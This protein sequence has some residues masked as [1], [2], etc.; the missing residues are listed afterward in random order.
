M[1]PVGVPDPEGERGWRDVGRWGATT[2]AI[3][4]SFLQFVFR[5]PLR[6][7]QELWSSGRGYYRKTP[8]EVA[9]VESGVD[10][11]PGFVWN[12]VVQ[13]DGR[14]FLTVDTVVKYV[15]HEWLSRRVNGGGSPCCLPP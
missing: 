7:N 14:I 10:T 8:L 1:P 11:H 4:V 15:D 12:V 3:G 9:G 13:G 2:G 5:T 6:R